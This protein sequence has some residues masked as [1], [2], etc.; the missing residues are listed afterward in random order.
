[1]ARRWVLH[2]ETKGTGAH[3]VPL[4][5]VQ[6]RASSVEPVFRLRAP[7]DQPAPPEPPPRTP[8]RFKVVELMTRQTLAED[9]GVREVVDALR[10][11]RSVV[12]VNVYLWDEAHERWQ[13]LP[14]S[15]KRTLFDR[16]HA[17]E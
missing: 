2:T 14:M 1:M 5:S 12:D 10:D 11:V 8:H 6:S 7:A 13:P 4:E 16:G 15:D 9:V 3:I 17:P